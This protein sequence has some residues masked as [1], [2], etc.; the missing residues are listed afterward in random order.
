MEIRLV[1]ANILADLFA[2]YSKKL[3]AYMRNEKYSIDIILNFVTG[4]T[5]VTDTCSKYLFDIIMS[6]GFDIKSEINVIVFQDSNEAINF[7]NTTEKNLTA[8]LDSY[9]EWIKYGVRYAICLAKYY[10]LFVLTGKDT[11]MPEG[12]YMNIP[13]KDHTEDYDWD[14]HNFS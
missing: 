13:D 7:L 11:E 2:R 3:Y 14:E 9:N 1:T 10:I 12:L 8:G 4:Y 5:I 6:E